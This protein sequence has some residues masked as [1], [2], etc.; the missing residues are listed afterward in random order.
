MDNESVPLVAPGGS[1]DLSLPASDENIVPISTSTAPAASSATTFERTD[2]NLIHSAFTKVRRVALLVV[3]PVVEP[4]VADNVEAF[5][6]R[7]LSG[8][9]DVA[10]AS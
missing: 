9:F 7:G 6:S 4:A 2:R 3:E 1:A 5:I 10:V 8:Q